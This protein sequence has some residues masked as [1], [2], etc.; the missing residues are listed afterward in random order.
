MLEEEARLLAELEE[1]KRSRLATWSA[2]TFPVHSVN[3]EGYRQLVESDTAARAECNRVR[4]TLRSYR[5]ARERVDRLLTD[6]TPPF[7]VVYACADENRIAHAVIT[8]D[9]SGLGKGDA[10]VNVTTGLRREMIESRLNAEHFDIQTM[11]NNGQLAFLDAATLLSTFMADGMPDAP[12]FKECVGQIIETASLDPA[13]GQPRK[14]RIFAEM[15]DLLYL[16]GNI[17]AAARLEELW[18]EV[19][20]AHSL[21]LFCAY[22]LKGDSDR[23]PQ[24]LLDHHSHDVLSMSMVR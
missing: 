6:A 19:L 7:H 17:P 18:N 4:A 1:C 11:Q 2:L 24:P 23:L 22:S 5:Q 14:V 10:V 12:I 3:Y 9:A 15:V 20:P 13:S 21:S 16:A 8:F